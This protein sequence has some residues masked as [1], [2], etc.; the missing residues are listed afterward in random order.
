MINSSFLG[1][2]SALLFI[3]F[4]KPVVLNR[5]QQPKLPGHNEMAL[6][7]VLLLIGARAFRY[8]V[9]ECSVRIEGDKKFSKF[10]IALFT[11]V[12]KLPRTAA[13]QDR[14]VYT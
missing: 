13:V 14:A 12:A 7:C 3:L 9:D 2:S 5:R 8:D 10:S 1:T 4:L 11:S 6:L